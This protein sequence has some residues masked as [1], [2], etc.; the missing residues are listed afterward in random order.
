MRADASRA[1]R[2]KETG[3]CGLTAHVY[4]LSK[5][6]EPL[7]FG[8]LYG[9]SNAQASPP[10]HLRHDGPGAGGRDNGSVA[11]R[12]W[13]I[14][15]KELYAKCLIRGLG[16]PEKKEAY[17]GGPT[18]SESYFSFISATVLPR[19]V[20]RFASSPCSVRNWAN[21]SKECSKP[22]GM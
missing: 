4:I 12:L 8:S 1:I 20:L 14:L 22:P 5:H 16:G 17:R 11:V 10:E 18:N 9:F 7:S 6:N 2:K 3:H 13:W 19:P 21:S 15:L